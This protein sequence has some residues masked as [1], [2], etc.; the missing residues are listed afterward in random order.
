MSW[1]GNSSNGA[2]P[3]STTTKV[4][5]LWK[6]ILALEEPVE[7]KNGPELSD[8]AFEKHCMGLKSIEIFFNAIYHSESKLDDLMAETSSKDI[9]ASL[10]VALKVLLTKRT[11]ASCLR[12][13][14]ELVVKAHECWLKLDYNNH[15]A[16][17]LAEPVHAFTEEWQN[18]MM[19]TSTRIVKAFRCLMQFS[20]AQ[21]FMEKAYWGE[22]Y[23]QAQIA[24]LYGRDE[25]VY[26]LK[27]KAQ[28]YC[29]GKL[30]DVCGSIL[31]C[32]CFELSYDYQTEMLRVQ[33]D[34]AEKIDSSILFEY[35]KD[36]LDFLH[37]E[38][39]RHMHVN[40]T[41]LP[42]LPWEVTGIE[43]MPMVLWIGMQR[44]DM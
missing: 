12:V 44:S 10:D 7:M 4:Q 23:L 41:K 25:K 1:L 36:W 42:T 26:F 31:A 34:P 27:G 2:R 19:Y 9:Q 5:Y 37:A 17:Q 6:F 22:G 39:C 18:G 28:K 30:A 11:Y 8:E 38:K 35:K 15:V 3:A 13:K 43:S 33:P 32:E 14:S 21:D 24:T 16:R 29:V 40:T 20:I